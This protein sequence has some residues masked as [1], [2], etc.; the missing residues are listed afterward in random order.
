MREEESQK[1]SENHG[2]STLCPDLLRKIIES[3]SSI[4]Y[5]R[6]KIVCSDWYG[7]WK[8]CVKRRL[9]PWRIVISKDDS[10]KFYDPGEDK[11]YTTQYVGLS[12]NS[13]YMASSGNWLLMINLPS[14]E[15]PIRGAQVRFERSGESRYT[16]GHFVEPCRKDNVS[17]DILH[18]KRSGV[19]LWINERTGDY[20]VAWIL[21]RHYLFTYKKGDDS[22]W[23]WNKDW[24]T[25]AKNLGYLDVAY[26]NSKL[27]LYTTDNHI[28]I[29]DFSG[30][31]PK[32]EIENN[33][34][35]DH[36]FNYAPRG[37]EV[38]PKRRI[39][40]Q[41]SG[42]ILIILNLVLIRESKL[43]FYIFKMNLESGKWERVYS[44]G[45]DE[46]IIFGHGVTIRAPVQDVGD[47]IKSGSI[48]FVFDGGLQSDYRC[49]SDCGI[50]DIAT[51]TIKWPK[52]FHCIKDK[53]HWFAPGFA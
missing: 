8:S 52:K 17:K 32:E 38:S 46:M 42:E 45:D 3:L 20:V 31:S 48:F 47:G 30:D 13:Y 50:F 28:K 43:L 33:P 35:L 24:I 7:V 5:Y 26:K 49:Y 25:G 34:Y 40:I 21:K 37:C 23:N 11:I 41:K 6:A 18:C 19:V 15:S 10:Y 39:A 36:H 22:W 1:V 44:I 14:I 4:D 51:S 9:C 29:I 16:W 2:W 12:D 53:S 27:Y